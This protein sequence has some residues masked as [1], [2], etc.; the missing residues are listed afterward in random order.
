MNNVNKNKQNETLNGDYLNR[1]ELKFGFVPNIYKAFL[2][3]DNAL[4]NYLELSKSE[5]NL[6]DKEKIIVK[7]AVS[8]VNGSNYSLSQY[9]HIGLKRSL[10]TN[11]TIESR[12][13]RFTSDE[14]FNALAELSFSIAQNRGK[15]EPGILNN[16]FKAGYTKAILMDLFL[17]VGEIIIANYIAQTLKLAIDFPWAPYINPK[18]NL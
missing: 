7:L 9:T 8:E 14:K 15:I 16:F 6:S 4:V 11:E 18:V 2:N 12:K 5:S 17:V 13:G 3:S 10:N 1:I